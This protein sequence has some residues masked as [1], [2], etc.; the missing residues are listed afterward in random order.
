MRPYHVPR[1]PAPIDLYL[2]GN[3]GLAAPPDLLAG[4][5]GADAELARRY[6]SPAALEARLA[7]LHG[8]DPAQVLVT[9][10]ADDALDRACRAFLAPGR[11]IVLP[12]P[13]F[14]MLERY[15]RLAGA[16]VR[17]VPWPGGPY[18]VEAVEAAITPETALVA[19]VSPNNPTGAAA[20]PDDLRRIAAHDAVVLV[21]LAY[22]EFA[23]VDLTPT[24]LDLPNALVFRSLSK[25]WGLAGLR[26]GYVMGPAGLVGWLRACGQP[27]A[28]SGP[29]LWL[30]ARRLEDAAPEMSGFVSR[31]QAE[32]RHLAETLADLGA[33]PLPSQGNF[34]FARHRDPLW[35][36]D[37]MAGLGV[38]VRAW[39][40]HATLGDAL[41]ITCPGDAGAF[42][43][44]VHGLRAVVKPEAILFDLDGVLAD[45]ADSYRQAIIG[46]AASY[47]VEV[48]PDDIREAK[49]RGHA[50][51]D[52]V[53][54]QGLLRARGV[55]APLDEVT[56]RF[57]RLYQ[58]DDEQPGLW[59]RERLIVERGWLEKLAA[60]RPLA[61][62][63]G[64]PRLDAERFLA[65]HELAR[66][67]QAVVVMQDAPLKPDPAPVRLALRRLGVE[68]AWMVGDT[69]DDVRAA[70][71]AGVVPLGVA[72]PGETPESARATLLPA[73]A[74]RV[75]DR[76]EDLEA[77]L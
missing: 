11:A 50:N 66:L 3:E 32:R 44:L 19:L 49:R 70:R 43:R 22:G 2:D 61:I 13:T 36:R 51:N 71:A 5:A 31:V 35:I 47:G 25:A 74:A 73:G 27:Y 8:V 64:R 77:W 69:P 45:V 37:G 21:D 65:Q 67:F 26:V 28:V 14:E 17:T 54:T 42:D 59:I 16:E 53:L 57:E 72:G 15:A 23:E 10:G 76:V 63:T 7:A 75:L 33:S 52:G 62:V 58:G 60:R 55:D 56:E 6:P 30:A 24:A 1:H 12:V 29:S 40:G 68:R 46:A 38:G 18:P 20:S 4:L 39:P 34:V 9:A 41:R 48:T